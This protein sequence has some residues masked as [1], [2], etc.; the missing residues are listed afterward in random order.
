MFEAEVPTAGLPNA[1]RRPRNCLA[2]NAIPLGLGNRRSKQK[3]EWARGE[4]AK[5][6][7]ELRKF[8]QITPALIIINSRKF[9]KLA[10]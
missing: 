6:V 8:S 7:R 4:P 3:Q 2:I 10:D 1:E 9:A 5:G